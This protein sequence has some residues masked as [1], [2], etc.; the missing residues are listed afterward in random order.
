MGVLTH[1]QRRILCRSIGTAEQHVQRA[2]RNECSR[3]LYLSFGPLHIELRPSSWKHC[4]P[5]R[6]PK[7]F[8]FGAGTRCQRSPMLSSQC[9]VAGQLRMAE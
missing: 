6:V 7:H 3:G 9:S 5:G 1:I 4:K 8:S 2:K